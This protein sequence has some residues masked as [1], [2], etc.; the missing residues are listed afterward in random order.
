V[1]PG[2][3]IGRDPAKERAVVPPELVFRFAVALFWITGPLIEGA[4]V[5]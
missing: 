1:A 3:L 5:R 2:A 4:V